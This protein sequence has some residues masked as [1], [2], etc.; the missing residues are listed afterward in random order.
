MNIFLSVRLARFQKPCLVLVTRLYL[1]S[2]FL[3]VAI[4]IPKWL[5][6]NYPHLQRG[7]RLPL[8]LATVCAFG[9][10]RLI[11]NISQFLIVS[12]SLKGWITEA[13]SAISGEKDLQYLFF[14]AWALLMLKLF[15]YFPHSYFSPQTIPPCPSNWHVTSAKARSLRSRERRADSP[16]NVDSCV[17]ANRNCQERHKHQAR[18]GRVKENNNFIYMIHCICVSIFIF[19]TLHSRIHDFLKQGEFRGLCPLK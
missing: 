11:V 14:L 3:V 12:L 13:T 6:L 7:N 8:C 9:V 4:C 1:A 16:A 15:P 19:L 5:I 17:N 10:D 2:T 18:S